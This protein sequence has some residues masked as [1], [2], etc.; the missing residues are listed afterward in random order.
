[1][2]PDDWHLT[3]NL[4]AFLARAGDFLRSRPVLHT[5]ALTVT[6]TLRTRGTAVYGSEPPVL[7]VL[8]RAG[9]VRAVLFRTPPHPLRLTAL[10]P[11]GAD[12][13]AARLAA[14]GHVLPGVGADRDTAVAFAAAW[15][16]HTGATPVLHER[17]RLY[18]LGTP[19]PPEPAPEGRARVAGERDRE[20]L[21]R[22]YRE[23]GAAVG[24]GVVQDHGAWADA[25]VAAGSV[26]LWETPDGTPVAMAGLTPMVAGQI[27]VVPVYTPPHLRGR[28]YAGAAV[29]G[30]GRAARAA[31]AAEV[32]LFADPDSPTGTALYQRLG[33]R[34]VA[35]FVEYAFR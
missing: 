17:A 14:L 6:E 25:Q 12:A 11:D 13:L 9:R 31:G 23:F 15:R 26:T 18:R 2:R 8:E 16:R 5:L 33:Y 32:L 22:W 7:G 1:M 29:V 21:A 30:A 35:D 4:D 3:G 34:P 10:T 20:R 24:G 19:T 28:G 27:R